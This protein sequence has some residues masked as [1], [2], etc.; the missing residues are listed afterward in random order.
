MLPSCYPYDII[1][2][3]STQ[4]MRLQISSVTLYDAYQSVL[5]SSDKEDDLSNRMRGSV[6]STFQKVQRIN[7]LEFSYDFLCYHYIIVYAL[8]TQI[9]ILQRSYI[10]WFYDSQSLS[11]S[12]K[13]GR[14]FEKKDGRFGLFNISEGTDNSWARSSIFFFYA[15]ITL[16]FM[17]VYKDYVSTKKS[18]NKFY[19]VNNVILCSFMIWCC[20]CSQYLLL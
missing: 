11:C 13:V 14:E 16:S 19:Y 4:I 20:Y 18:P 5:T 9:M 3:Y 15:I 1:Y 6:R 7:E 10:I 8:F 2:A 12:P 17:Q